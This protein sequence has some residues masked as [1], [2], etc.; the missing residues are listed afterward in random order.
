[1]SVSTITRYHRQFTALAIVAFIALFVASWAFLTW[2]PITATAA[3]TVC[4]AALI[5]IAHLRRRH[6]ALRFPFGPVVV[7]GTLI[8]QPPHTPLWRALT[9]W[10]VVAL[11]PLLIIPIGLAAQARADTPGDVAYLTTL[12]QFGVRYGSEDAAIALGHSVC[13]GLG[14]GILPRRVALLVADGGYSVDDARTIVGASIGAYCDKYM[15]SATTASAPSI[16]AAM[17]GAIR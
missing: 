8:E 4:T 3:A 16:G 6:R 5:C 14:A 12:D 13:D 17:G 11:S 9:P 2:K 1:V 7:H 15:P 10:W